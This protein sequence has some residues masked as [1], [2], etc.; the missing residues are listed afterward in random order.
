MAKGT[1][2]HQ[3]KEDI[4]GITLYM[5]EKELTPCAGKLFKSTG[6]VTL[7]AEI[8]DLNVWDQVTDKLDGMTVYTV[9]GLTEA[10]V[11]AAQRR[12]TRAEKRAMD[13]MEQA[14]RSVDDLEAAVSFLERD[15]E[16][17][18]GQIAELLRERKELQEVID[19]QDAALEGA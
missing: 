11:Q 14:R 17:L 5:K 9:N 8:N 1:M 16:N 7:R 12:A 13:T 4:P 18:K 15:N 6:F 10:I 19:V 2:I 3:K